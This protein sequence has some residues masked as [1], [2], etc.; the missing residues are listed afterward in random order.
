VKKVREGIRLEY[1]EPVRFNY[2]EEGPEIDISMFGRVSVG[3]VQT[4]EVRQNAHG[5]P[6]KR[7]IAIDG[8]P[9]DAKE[10]AR[11]DAEHERRKQRR[12][13]E[14]PRQRSARL[15]EEADEIRERDEI[16]DDAER[17]FAFSYVARDSVDGQPVSVF[18]LTPRPNARIT[19]SEGERMKKFAGRIWIAVDDARIA[20]V[21]LH[22]MDSVT[23]G[24]GVVARVDRGSG[25]D[26]V[27]KKVAGHWVASSLTI[28]G[29]GS[30]LMFR[31]FTVKTVTNYWGHQLR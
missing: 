31:S 30:T 25:F 9:L 12:R 21:R 14:S 19:T 16:L 10:L 2:I 27:R 1:A 18:D 17:V 26:F 3:P 13:D 5:D 11:R 28:E 8:K 6:W 24:W 20:R 23:V 29:S 22:A 15:R 4:F 7:L